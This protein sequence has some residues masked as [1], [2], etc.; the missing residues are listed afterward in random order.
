MVQYQE[1]VN[2]NFKI[3]TED[4]EFTLKVLP[5]TFHLNFE[6]LKY[7]NNGSKVILP[8]R[9][10]NELSSYEN[11]AFPI[12]IKINDSYL[13]VHDFSDFID[14]M[15]IPNYYF[16][17][18]NLEENEEVKISILHKPLEKATYIKIKPLDDSFYYIENKKMYLE[19][20][21]KNLY[22]VLSEEQTIN[23]IYGEK[24]IPFYIMS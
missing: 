18:L 1:N 8:K 13:G 11:V 6:K 10:L 9:I 15:Y 7:K 24:V 2:E 19:T 17:N 16:Y 4:I 21:I 3:N 12:T 23:L 5:F 22:N 20:H 14:E